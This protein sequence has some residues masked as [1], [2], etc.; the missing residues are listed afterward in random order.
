MRS[1]QRDVV[2][3]RKPSLWWNQP[4]TLVEGCTRC[5][6]GCKDCWALALEA[7]SGAGR[8]VPPE[9]TIR[10]R[11]DRLD[12]PLRWRK[13]RVV[14]VWNDL[15]HPDVPYAFQRDTFLM[16]NEPDCERHTFIVLTKRSCGAQ[17]FHDT[18]ND[19]EWLARPWSPWRENII[20][21][22]TC[23]S[24]EYLWR[25]DTLLA[26]P[27]ACRFVN[28]HLL[29]PLGL[30]PVAFGG[31]PESDEWARHPGHGIDWLAIECNRPFR[32]DPAEWWGWCEALVDQATAAGVPVWVK[33][34]PTA[35]GGVTHDIAEFPVACRRRE[36]PNLKGASDE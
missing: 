13:P 16:M 4:L 7:R 20:L 12:E 11:R 15:F 27:A 34:G 35:T 25:V 29:G 3:A 22:V 23:E 10:L 5:S 30:T 14:A 2:N 21:G 8:D 36:F 31:Y 26:T 28:A 6:A 32:G 33:Q 9:R 24:D 1:E 18:W 19:Q 17:G